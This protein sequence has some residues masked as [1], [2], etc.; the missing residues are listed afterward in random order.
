MFKKWAFS[1]TASLVHIP[2]TSVVHAGP[3]CMA[4]VHGL[5]HGPLEMTQLAHPGTNRPIGSE[6]APSHPLKSSAT[7]QLRASLGSEMPP[8]TPHLDSLIPKK[9]S[10]YAT[11]LLNITS[12]TE[13]EEPLADLNILLYTLAPQDHGYSFFLYEKKLFPHLRVLHQF[14]ESLPRVQVDKGAIKFVLN[15]ADIMCPGLTSKGGS[16]D[17]ELPKHSP[18]AVFAEGM[19]HPLA[20]GYTLMSTEDM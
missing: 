14:P 4:W 16:L 11:K 2:C 17:T 13:D 1:C 18:V 9:A 10:L 7:R 15:G 19:E 8:L 3:V 20:V 6:G 12:N 5:R